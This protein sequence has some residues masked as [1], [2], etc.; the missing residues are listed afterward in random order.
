MS[1]LKGMLDKLVGATQKGSVP[2][3]RDEKEKDEIKTT[4]QSVLIDRVRS[5]VKSTRPY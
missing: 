3:K 2:I 5:R 4:F 1:K